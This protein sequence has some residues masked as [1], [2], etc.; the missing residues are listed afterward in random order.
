MDLSTLQ[1][2]IFWNM[3]FAW[4]NKYLMG[5]YVR[6]FFK[7]SKNLEIRQRLSNVSS[8]LD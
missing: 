4:G 7:G 2:E 1:L 8:M 5:N 6:L 3:Y